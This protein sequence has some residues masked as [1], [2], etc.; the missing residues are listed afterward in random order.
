MLTFYFLLIQQPTPEAI[1][2]AKKS[3]PWCKQRKRMGH[4]TKCTWCDNIEQ[5][6]RDDGV[7]AKQEIIPQGLGQGTHLLS[8]KSSDVLFV[9]F[10]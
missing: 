3:S 1:Q 6:C 5:P 7:G 10:Q 2:T 9:A 8:V 4:Q